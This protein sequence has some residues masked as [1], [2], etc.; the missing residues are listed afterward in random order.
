MATGEKKKKGSGRSKSRR[1]SLKSFARGKFQSP[2]H[3]NGFKQD[4]LIDTY[5]GDVGVVARNAN[6]AAALA[7]G[8]GKDYFKYGGATYKVRSVTSR[9]K[10]NIDAIMDDRTGRTK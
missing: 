4:M 5:G 2:G 9:G 3:S 8:E 1:A 10:T 6:A 7:A